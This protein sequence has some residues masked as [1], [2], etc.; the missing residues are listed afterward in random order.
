MSEQNKPV[1]RAVLDAFTAGDLD[2]L[3]AYHDEHVPYHGSGGEERRGREGARGAAAMYR[4][5]V[6]DGTI[7]EEWEIFDRADLASQLGE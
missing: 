3:A 1:V 5:A 4:E 6:P 2:T 7:V